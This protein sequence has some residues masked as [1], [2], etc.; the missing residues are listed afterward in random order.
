MA[1]R[2]GVVGAGLIGL[3]VA[4]ELQRGAGD[5]VVTVLE[6]ETAV[7]RHQSGHNSGVA[8]AGLYYAP[9]S[10]KAQLCR[11]GIGLL[12]QYSEQHGIAYEECGKLVIARDEVELGRLDEIE[13]RA[14]E[15]GVPGLRR[16]AAEQIAEVEPAAVGVAALHSPQTA[17]VDFPAVARRLAADVEDVGGS[18][19]LGF[20]VARIERAKRAVTVR[21]RSGEALAFDWLV[22]CAGLQSDRLARRAGGGREPAIV[23][24][25]GEYYELVDE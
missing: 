11:R 23:P 5:A 22:L 4:R 9:G 8:H 15:N 13:R 10:L 18:V 7:A 25:R 2:I 14:R 1:R 12:K 6:K 19:R 16:L 3:A 21:G 24:F 17:I 20:E